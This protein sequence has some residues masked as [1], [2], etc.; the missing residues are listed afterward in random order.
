M[1]RGKNEDGM[2]ETKVEWVRMGVEWVR[3]GVE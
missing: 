2:G 3:M 1:I